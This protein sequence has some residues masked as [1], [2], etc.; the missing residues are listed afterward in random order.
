MMSD[1]VTTGII[2]NWGDIGSYY[3]PYVVDN[4]VQRIA[5]ELTEILI[6]INSDRLKVICQ[7]LSRMSHLF[8]TFQL[9]R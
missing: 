2:I 4:Y 1:A 3:Y 6:R 7:S 8:H 9:A 5:D